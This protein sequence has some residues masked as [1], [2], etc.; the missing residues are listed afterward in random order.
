MLK[1]AIIGDLFI[2]AHLVE[3]LLQHHLQPVIGDFVVVSREL[4]WPDDTPTYNAELREYV[5]DP[6][7]IAR[8]VGDADIVV[9]QVAPIS[10][11]L[12]QQAPQLQVIAC[13]RGGPVSVNIA[14]A[15]MRGIPVL[16]AP[17]ANAQAV[18]EFT[19]GLILAES[20]GIACGHCAAGGRRMARRF[21]SL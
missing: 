12:I 8:F 7:E 5:G 1:V 13:A 11:A 10:G 19:L 4:G 14:A 16:Y 9:T 3:E 20:K 17:G 6:V 18:V 15:K 21:L 2:R